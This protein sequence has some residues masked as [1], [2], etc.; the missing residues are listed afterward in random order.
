MNADV[1][2][3]TFWFETDNCTSGGA[4]G[5]GLHDT[6]MRRPQFKVITDCSQKGV[7]WHEGDVECGIEESRIKNHELV[8]MA[9]S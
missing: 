4:L 1:G 8:T 6:G 9:P 3:V 5:D 7:S 2:R